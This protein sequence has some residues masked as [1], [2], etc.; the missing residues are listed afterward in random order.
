MS[1]SIERSQ[2]SA[3]DAETALNDLA[4]PGFQTA[5][6]NMVF[7]TSP[8]DLEFFASELKRRTS[9]L[10]IGCTT[11]GH[12][13]STGFANAGAVCLSFSPEK[14][15]CWTWVID[16]VNAPTACIERIRKDIDELLKTVDIGSTFGVLLTDGLCGAE[17]NLIS[18]LFGALPLIPI[19]GGSAGDHLT[20]EAT[21]VLHDGEFRQGVS[22]FT[23]ISTDLPFSIISLKHHQPTPARLIVTKAN[24]AA[25]RVV[26]FNGMPAAEAYAD[27]VGSRVSDLNSVIFAKHPLMVRVGNEHYIRSPRNVEDNNDMNFFCA[28]EEGIVLRIGQSESAL[29]SLQEAV[30]QAQSRVAGADAMLVFDCILRRLELEADN[31]DK[32]AGSIFAS[33]HAVG[34]STYGEQ[35]DALHVNQTMVGI[36]FGGL[37]G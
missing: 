19:V 20:F 3:S 21:Y 11:S 14:T 16:D 18:S 32:E 10:V 9:G 31:L 23:L 8:F 15:A 30:D 37:N 7:A 35:L 17:E 5:A 28:L 24:A 2:T 12:I 26:E 36:A 6:V 4:T 27:A 22:T 29:E 33:A 34:F 13:D 1:K 25:R